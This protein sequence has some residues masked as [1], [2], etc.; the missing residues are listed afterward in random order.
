MWY[1]INTFISI[2]SWENEFCTLNLEIT[3]FQQTP[4]NIK[5]KKVKPVMSL[6]YHIVL[7]KYQ[8][9]IIITGN[10]YF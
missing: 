7:Q 9:Y 4:N 3:Y 6:I 8:E 5:F 2:L 1:K 10:L